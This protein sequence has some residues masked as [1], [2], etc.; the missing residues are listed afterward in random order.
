MDIEWLTA[1]EVSRYLKVKPRTV[2]KW[3]KEG[4]IP[5]A[6]CGSKSFISHTSDFSS[7]TLTTIF[8]PSG[9]TVPELISRT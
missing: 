5:G 3:A 4:R 2:L 1:T 7:P 9:L 6:V 8:R